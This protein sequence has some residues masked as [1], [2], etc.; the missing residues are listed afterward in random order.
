MST[1]IDADA[2]VR[3]EKGTFDFLAWIE[4]HPD[5]PIAFPATVWQ[6]L[7]FGVFGWETAR[8]A[9]RS[10]YLFLVGTVPVVPFTRSHAVRAAQLSA[11]L[12]LS[13]IGFSD[14]QIAATALVDD[15]QLLT[16]STRRTS[17]VCQT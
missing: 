16:S 13:Q 2:F 7:A 9:K 8:A 12:K 1:Y 15:A 11:G 5:E 14:C 10:R 4:Q 17:P 6:Q 3:W